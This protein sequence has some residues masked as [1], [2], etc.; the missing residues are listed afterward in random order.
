MNLNG[1]KDTDQLRKHILP[2]TH[3]PSKSI[4]SLK[5]LF[6][7]HPGFDRNLG[8][9]TCSLTQPLTFSKANTWIQQ[10]QVP[11]T[12]LQKLK[13]PIRQPKRTA[14]GPQDR[15]S[16]PPTHG[17]PISSKQAAALP[18]WRLYTATRARQGAQSTHQRAALSLLQ[19]CALQHTLT[20]TPNEDT[21][22][23]HRFL[24]DRFKPRA[25]KK[26]NFCARFLISCQSN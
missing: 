17:P 18:T 19:T 24:S 9:H 1:V 13:A 23:R 14:P 3:P 5:Q 11:T 10:I 20:Q 21:F 16:R 7:Q 12:Q 15:G 2:R 25:S 22:L 6:L 8:V 26:S 4:T